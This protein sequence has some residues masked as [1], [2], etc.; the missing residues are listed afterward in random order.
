[1]IVHMLQCIYGCWSIKAAWHCL[2]RGDRGALF[3]A[4][5][6]LA[7]C[8]MLTQAARAEAEAAQ[9]T[10]ASYLAS[11]EEQLS[12]L[13]ADAAQSAAGRCGLGRP[14]AWRCRKEVVCLSMGAAVPVFDTTQ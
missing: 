6:G 1:M 14:G 5:C 3:C 4:S 9:S 8:L 7:G 12:S 13:G 2:Q 11:Y 10:L